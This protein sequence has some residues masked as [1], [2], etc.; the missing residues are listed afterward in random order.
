MKSHL[1]WKTRHFWNSLHQRTLDG[2]PLTIP[3]AKMTDFWATVE[4]KVMKIGKKARAVVK[5]REA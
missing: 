5:D 3:M 2:D 4:I 1:S